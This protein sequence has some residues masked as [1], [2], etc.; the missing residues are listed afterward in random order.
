M[1]RWIRAFLVECGITSDYAPHSIRHAST[2]TALKK[3]VDLSVIK[4]LAGWSQN[5]QTFD[6]FYNRPLVKD[7][8]KFAKA[9]LLNG[10][11]TSKQ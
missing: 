11:S 1:S 8:R 5:S 4:S 7:R 3:G 10:S 6:R 9:V 2:S